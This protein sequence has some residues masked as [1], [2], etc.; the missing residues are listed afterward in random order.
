MQD[1]QV[2]GRKSYAEANPEL[3]ELARELSEQRSRLS[4]R[5]IST[6]LASKGS[7]TPR[8]LPYSASAVAS[9]LAR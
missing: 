2:E 7:T 4:L 8:G 1:Q 3:V 9:M 5:E 6:A